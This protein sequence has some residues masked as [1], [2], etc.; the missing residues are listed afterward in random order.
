MSNLE[1]ASN[2]YDVV[3]N[4]RLGNNWGPVWDAMPKFEEAVGKLSEDKSKEAQELRRK[5]EFMKAADDKYW[6]EFAD[7]GF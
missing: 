4:A 6:K 7:A 5:L 2:A 1:L 3:V